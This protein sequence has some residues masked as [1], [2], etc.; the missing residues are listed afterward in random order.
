MSARMSSKGMHQVVLAVRV[1][2]SLAARTLLCSDDLL[3]SYHTSQVLRFCNQ[4]LNVLAELWPLAVI[5]VNSLH[6]FVWLILHLFV[7][8]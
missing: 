3:S 2:Q 7:L 8:A 6:V 4:V 5:S 1:V